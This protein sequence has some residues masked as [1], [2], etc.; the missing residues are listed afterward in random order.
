MNICWKYFK[1]ITGKKYIFTNGSRNHAENTLKRLGILDLFERI[2]SI[3][4]TVFTPKPSL[5]SFFM[6]TDN[7]GIDPEKSIFFDDTIENLL[8]RKS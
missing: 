6:F 3:E 5:E 2:F 4:D 1:K 7:V 8:P